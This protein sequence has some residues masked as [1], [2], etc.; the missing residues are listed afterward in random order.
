MTI[1][2][3]QIANSPQVQA[4]PFSADGKFPFLPSY[5]IRLRRFRT[6]ADLVVT[7]YVFESRV[8]RLN[9]RRCA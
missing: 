3:L 7:I 8:A 5:T 4:S 2:T 1:N 6:C 9:I